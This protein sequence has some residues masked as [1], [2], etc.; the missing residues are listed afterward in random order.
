MKQAIVF[1]FV[2]LLLLLLL[3]PAAPVAAQSRN[4]RT[5][6]VWVLTSKNNPEGVRRAGTTTY[7]NRE[8]AIRQRDAARTIYPLA[9]YQLR[10][11]KRKP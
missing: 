8:T 1:F 6:T 2:L 7:G 11:V 5:Q 4:R 3:L 9:D 10:R